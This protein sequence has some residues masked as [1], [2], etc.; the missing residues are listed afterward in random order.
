VSW[1]PYGDGHVVVRRDEVPCANCYLI[2]CTTERLRCLTAIDVS[3]VW[4]ACR[5]A[6]RARKAA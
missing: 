2:E 5:T 3:T 4:A 6:L 1:H